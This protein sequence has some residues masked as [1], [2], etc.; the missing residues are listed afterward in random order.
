MTADEL[1]GRIAAHRATVFSWWFIPLG[2]RAA[3]FVAPLTAL[4]LASGLSHAFGSPKAKG[5]RFI[6]LSTDR[7]DRPEQRSLSAAGVKG[8]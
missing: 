5:L 4:L 6:C 3:R 2:G 8:P 1:A 7:A